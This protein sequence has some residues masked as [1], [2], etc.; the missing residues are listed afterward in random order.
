MA[1]DVLTFEEDLP[2]E[3]QRVCRSCK[4]HRL[5]SPPLRISRR[6]SLAQPRLSQRSHHL[7]GGTRDRRG[8]E[9][10]RAPDAA[11]L[12]IWASAE[13]GQYT[14]PRPMLDIAPPAIPAAETPGARRESRP[15]KRPNALRARPV[16]CWPRTSGS[17][18]PAYRT[19]ERRKKW[20]EVDSLDERRSNT[21]ERSSGTTTPLSCH[22]HPHPRHRTREG[23]HR[24]T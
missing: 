16:R 10:L 13:Q 8:K 22:Q 19:P 14:R 18:R 20:P 4:L 12:F 1:L 11:L 9:A 5:P 23:T 6:T 7:R 24:G 15:V 3:P 17:M 21:P 2:G